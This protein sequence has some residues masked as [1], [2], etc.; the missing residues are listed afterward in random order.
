MAK[1][2]ILI[3]REAPRVNTN[4]RKP[5]GYQG[6]LDLF[7][8]NVVEL[9]FLRRLPIPPDKPVGH[10]KKTRRMLATN[11]WNFIKAPIVR[12]MLEWKPPKRPPR[13]SQWYKQRNLVIVWDM[14]LKDWRMIN[15]KDWKIIATTPI[16]SLLD[17]GRFIWF[18]KNK[19]DKMSDIERKQFS[20][21]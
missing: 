6:I 16:D 14:L 5:F 19:I 21:K 8:N 10:A 15:L 9:K 17:K 4:P 12:N 11:N 20:D 18:Y 13:G 7:R 1:P 2:R 3:K